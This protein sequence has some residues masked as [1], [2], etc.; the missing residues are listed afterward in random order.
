MTEFRTPNDGIL[1]RQLVV[2]LFYDAGASE[3]RELPVTPRELADLIRIQSAPEKASLP[4]LKLAVFGEIRTEK[5]SLRHDANVKAITGVEADYDGEEITFEAA[6]ELLEKQGIAAI[7]YTSPSHTEAK[8]RFR[9]VAPVSEELPPDKRAHLV[10]RLNGLFRGAFSAESFTLSQAYYYGSVNGN[11]AHQVELIDGLPI[12]LHDDL[13]EIWQ[14]KQGT[15]ASGT[16]G[17]STNRGTYGDRLDVEAEFEKL[18]T[19][20]NYHVAAVR[21]FGRF[22]AKGVGMVEALEIV[23]D[24]MRVVP[25]AQRDARWQQRYDDL[26]RCAEQIY[27]KN[28]G[29]GETRYQRREG[30]QAQGGDAGQDDPAHDAPSMAVLRRSAQPAPELPLDVFG[31]FWGPWIAQ[32]AQGANVPPDYVAVPLLAATSALIGNAR[33]PVGWPGWAEAPALWFASVGNPS[34]GKTSGA[35]PI[36]R[37]VLRLVEDEISRG[38]PA[39]MQRWEE[40]ASVARAVHEQ[41]KRDVA[42]AVKADEPAPKKPDAAAEPPKPVRPRVRVSDVTVEKLALVLQALPKGVLYHRDELAGW[43]LNLSRY[44]GGTDRPFWLEAYN[45]GT[46]QVDRVK[47]PEPIIIPHLTVPVFG[48]IQPDRLGEVLAGADDGL[49]SRILWCWPEAREFRQPAIAADPGAAARCLL[50][51]AKMPMARTI[52]GRPEPSYVSLAPEARPYLEEFGR[53]MQA[54]EGAAYGLFKSALGKCRGQVLRLSLVLEYLW[55]CT[56]QD[57]EPAEVSLAAFQAAAALMD[58]YFIPNAARVLADASIPEEEHH[59]RT[60]AEWIIRTRPERVNVSAIR[61]DA[62]LPGLRKSD[63]VKAACRYLEEARWL[64]AAP[65]RGRPQGGRPRGDYLVNPK[66][67][68]AC[69]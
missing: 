18:R 20:E 46:Y 35:S 56:G 53:E 22:A 8:P 13:D 65:G 66:L 49:S 52:D 47:H 24:A 58:A 15:K 26:P 39:E 63:T 5:N 32:A 48:T 69:P 33:W 42:K 6:L 1:D 40:E 54:R 37:D 10:G 7:L 12:D 44:S 14:G 57:I 17:Q 68:E 62:R 30:E 29:K 60:I 19:G 45:G 67:W 28:L 51:L 43:L 27:G 4:W 23:R 55:W 11:P 3:K 9:V 25:E 34:S 2:T 41:W 50:R 31:P 38:Y 16:G 64:I 21:L 61:D 36:M 59:A